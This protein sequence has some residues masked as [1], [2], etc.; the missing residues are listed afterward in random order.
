VNAKRTN[1]PGVSSTNRPPRGR[2]R[3]RMVVKY[4][5]GGYRG[6][7]GPRGGRYVLFRRGADVY[8]SLV[9]P[10]EARACCSNAQHGGTSQLSRKEAP[11]SIAYLIEIPLLHARWSPPIATVLSASRRSNYCVS[12]GASA[13][14][15]SPIMAHTYL[16]TTTRSFTADRFCSFPSCRPS[17][18]RRS[19]ECSAF[20]SVGRALLV[21][22]GEENPEQKEPRQD[23]RR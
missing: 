19:S 15:T 6:S 1:K 12:T 9:E 13:P 10:R 23:I 4:I 22:L 18:S 2:G 14:S 11:L 20:R 21:A 3:A 7:R 8:V 17:K 5:Y 16:G